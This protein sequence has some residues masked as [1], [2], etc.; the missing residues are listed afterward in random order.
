MDCRP[1]KANCTLCNCTEKR[2][3]ILHNSSFKR[4]KIR[5]KSSLRRLDVQPVYSRYRVSAS[6]FWV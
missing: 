1:T 3:Q 6:V 4:T 2:A 5:G